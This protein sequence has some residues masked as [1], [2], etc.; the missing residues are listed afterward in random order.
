MA[1]NGHSSVIMKAARDSYVAADRCHG[2]TCG[3]FS[4]S[5]ALIGRGDARVPEELDRTPARRGDP[6]GHRRGAHVVAP[7]AV[8]TARPGSRLRDTQALL[9]P[10]EMVIA[11]P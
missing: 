9:R 2:G 8:L 10:D 6:D 4:R 7:G 5:R 1:R 11:A 3:P